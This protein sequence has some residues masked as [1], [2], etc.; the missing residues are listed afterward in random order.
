MNTTLLLILLPATLCIA[1]EDA[2]PKNELA[3]GLGGIPALS[4]NDSPRV[5]A[6]SGVT[7]QVNY[8]R[9]LLMDSKVALCGEINF[10]ASPLREVFSSD[11]GATHDFASLISR[12]ESGSRFAR[13]R[14][15]PRMRS[16]GPGMR[17]T[18]KA[19]RGSTATPTRPRENFRAAFSISAQ[20]STCMCGDSSHCV[21]K[22]AISTR[23]RRTTTSISGGQHNV[24]ATGAFV[25]RWH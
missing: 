3:F 19:S 13:H 1:Q 11:S 4:R 2:A 20:E 10:V 5:D 25:L 14:K 16:S 15:S 6:G 23:V 8:G 18:N 7:F 22:L 24:V 17:I 9:R 12:L 21:G